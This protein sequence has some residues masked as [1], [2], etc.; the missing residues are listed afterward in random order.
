MTRGKPWTQ[1]EEKELR[2]LVKARV[3]V[4]VIAE[5]LGKSIDAVTKKCERLGLVVVEDS[6][7]IASTTS[8][9]SLPKELPSVE[10]AL[11]MLAGALKR[12]CEPGLD[13]VEVQ[14]LQVIATLARTYKDILADY[15]DYRGLEKELLELGQ[16]FGELAKK[17]QS[18]ASK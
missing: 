18:L 12:A 8:C 5:K 4:G 3:N 6:C 17:T 2:E 15:L 11:I 9:L 7:R 13:K 14:R 10:E 16:Q 1:A